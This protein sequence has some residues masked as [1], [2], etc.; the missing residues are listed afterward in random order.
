MDFTV[1]ILSQ[2]HDDRDDEFTTEEAEGNGEGK[3]RATNNSG[4][5]REYR[6]QKN[7]ESQVF[8]LPPSE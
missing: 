2:R 1:M 3:Q 4:S 7:E 6:I 5:I 8:C